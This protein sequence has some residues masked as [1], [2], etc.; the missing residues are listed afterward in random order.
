MFAPVPVGMPWLASWRGPCGCGFGEWLA[1]FLGA[2]AV[3]AGVNTDCAMPPAGLMLPT[4]ICRPCD[5]FAIFVGLLDLV[6]R[7]SI[8]ATVD[9]VERDVRRVASAAGI[10]PGCPGRF[11]GRGR[12]STG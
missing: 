3:D 12:T 10:E 1:V 4:R 8:A 9:A 2:G 7:R 6:G 11:A 5:C